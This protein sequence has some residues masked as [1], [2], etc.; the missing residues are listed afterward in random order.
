[1]KLAH[2]KLRRESGEC[3]LNKRGIY[4]IN[5]TLKQYYIGLTCNG[6][7]GKDYPIE[8][9]E[10]H[11]TGIHDINIVFHVVKGYWMGVLKLSNPSVDI[12]EIHKAIKPGSIQIRDII[13]KE[14][15]NG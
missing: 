14:D 2:I 9:V 12:M 4:E 8:E 3:L 6:I 1:M 10:V 5:E 7:L 11:Y 13:V 15:N